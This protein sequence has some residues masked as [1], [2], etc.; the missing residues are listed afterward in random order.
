M[1]LKIG[2][3]ILALGLTAQA[4]AQS[5]CLQNFNVYGPL[6]AAAIT[7]R[8]ALMVQEL[9]SEATK[10]DVLQ[11]QE[12][13]TAD[14]I[15]QV[16]EAFKNDYRISAPNLQQRI[17]L[18]SLFVGQ[19]HGI[20]TDLFLH[21]SEGGVLD[22]IRNLGGVKKAF[23]IV[24]AQLNS[25]PEEFYFLNTHTHPTSSSLR[26]TQILDIY[27]WRLAHQDRKLVMSGDFNSEIGSLERALLMPL[28]GVHDSM[29][30]V[31][32]GTYPLGFCSY[33]EANAR[34]WMSGNHLFDYVFFSNVSESPRTLRPLSG[35]VNL[36]GQGRWGTLSDHYG[37]RVHLDLS[38]EASPAA[39]TEKRRL[40]LLSVLDK[41]LLQLQR[42]TSPEY[43]PS[44]T[45]LRE[46]RES[47]A[48]KSGAHW[49]YFALYR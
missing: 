38:N 49:D 28:L 27:Q 15:Q 41:A 1:F 16:N 7:N 35:E 48:Q 42:E 36:K 31:L 25:L 34:A 6:Y 17:G 44:L 40:R 10:C 46:I 29:E 2:V 22:S 23:H 14:H 12:V 9:Q 47:I 20:E 19:I 37:V 4:K 8:T 11:F 5:F 24:K 26:I 45:Q 18:M 43:A 33:C 21:N 30:E 32:G 39:D 3:L 13:W